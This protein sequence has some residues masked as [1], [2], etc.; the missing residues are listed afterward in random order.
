MMAN[1]LFIVKATISNREQETEWNDW[2]NEIHCREILRWPGAISARRLRLIMG[3][4]QFQYLTLYEFESEASFRGFWTS[5]HRN[6]ARRDYEQRFGAVSQ[7]GQHGAYE[8]LWR[9]FPG[10]GTTK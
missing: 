8:E 6:A 4:D 3:D 10:E 5:A 7:L 2:Y 9:G 1:V